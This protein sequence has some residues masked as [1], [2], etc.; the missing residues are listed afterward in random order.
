MLTHIGATETRGIEFP[1]AGVPGGHESHDVGCWKLS[2]DA[3][4]K[5]YALI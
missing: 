3:L 1:A 5:N 4:Y 2:L